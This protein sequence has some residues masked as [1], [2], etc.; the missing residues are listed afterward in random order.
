MV[1]VSDEVQACRRCSKCK[2][3]QDLNQF[4]ANHTSSW[5]RTCANEHARA[6]RR[7]ARYRKLSKLWRERPEVMEAR[8]EASR[9]SKRK[10]RWW[11][12]TRG[13]LCNLRSL[14]RYRAR[15]Y[16]TSGKFNSARKQW[17]RVNAITDELARLDRETG[18]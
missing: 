12:T 7:T 6:Y 2:E 8:R 1:V 15:K 11:Q 18:Q 13:K 17:D 4:R 9:K 16:E 5:C 3:I 10:T 14:A